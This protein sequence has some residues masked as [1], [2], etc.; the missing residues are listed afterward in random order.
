M[1]FIPMYASNQL[2]IKYNV[3]YNHLIKTLA[4]SILFVLIGVFF[5][6]YIMINSWLEFFFWGRLFGVIGLL[7][8]AI[9]S[10]NWTEFNKLV[11]IIKQ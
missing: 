1:V 4:F 11:T 2:K 5:K 9:I 10:L 3:L 8:N 7:I 6:S